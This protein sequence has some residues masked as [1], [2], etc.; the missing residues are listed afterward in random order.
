MNLRQMKKGET[1]G[2]TIPQPCDK[3]WD[4]MTAKENGKH[5]DTCNKI[6][7]DFT[8]MPTQDILLYFVNNTAQ[9]TCGHFYKGQIETKHNSFHLFLLSTYCKADKLKNT[10]LRIVAMALISFVLTTTGCNTSGRNGET[11][12]GDSSRIEQI[13]TNLVTTGV[14]LAPLKT[15]ST[16]HKKKSCNNN[17]TH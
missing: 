10:S 13:D 11:T 15:D 16:R 3:D 5:C 6:V 12:V 9:R 14:V 2:I 8:T 4:K 17:K 1:L 7:V